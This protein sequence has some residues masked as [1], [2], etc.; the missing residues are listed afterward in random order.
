MAKQLIKV[1][2]HN[3]LDGF[4]G[5]MLLQSVQPTVFSSVEFDVEHIGAGQIDATLDHWFSSLKVFSESGVISM[6]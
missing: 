5:P 2:S 1:F 6:M 3:D 4:G